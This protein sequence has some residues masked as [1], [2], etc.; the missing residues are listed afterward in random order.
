MICYVTNISYYLVFAVAEYL[1][2]IVIQGNGLVGMIIEGK[3]NERHVFIMHDVTIKYKYIDLNS[4]TVP[5]L[6][7][8]FLITNPKIQ[9]TH[10]MIFW[11]SKKKARN[12]E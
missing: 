1:L 12:N 4:Q 5:H 11:T 10:M 9:F 2:W 8:I 6:K 7:R 3:E